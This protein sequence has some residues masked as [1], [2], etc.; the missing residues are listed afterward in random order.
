[1]SSHEEKRLVCGVCEELL[2]GT[3]V[4]EQE[5]KAAADEHERAEHPDREQVVVVHVSTALL[6]EEPAEGMIE[7]AKGAQRRLDEGDVGGAMM[8]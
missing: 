5:A 8:G 3:Y 6:E 7:A 1:M 2:P 4:G